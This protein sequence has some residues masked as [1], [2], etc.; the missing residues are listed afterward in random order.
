MSIFLVQTVTLFRHSYVVECSNSTHAEELVSLNNI[1]E[2]FDQQY[3]REVITSTREITK[4][5]FIEM[6]DTADNG[7]LGDKIIYKADDLKQDR[8]NYTSNIDGIGI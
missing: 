6:A 4:Q 5:E 8:P 3:L 7:H 1:V 2:E